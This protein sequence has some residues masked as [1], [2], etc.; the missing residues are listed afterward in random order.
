MRELPIREP[1]E[2]QFLKLMAKGMK[3][4]IERRI[5]QEQNEEDGKLKEVDVD[6]SEQLCS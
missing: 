5:E 4:I 2:R 1:Y 6:T 3:I